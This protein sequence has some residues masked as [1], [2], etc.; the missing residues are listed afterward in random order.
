MDELMDI[1][2]EINP[3]IDYENEDNLIDGKKLDSLGIMMLISEICDRFDI[4]IG[5]KWMRNEN[6]NTVSAIWSMIEKI[7]EERK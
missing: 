2:M 7:R 3:D 4:E 1:L 5:A 6:F